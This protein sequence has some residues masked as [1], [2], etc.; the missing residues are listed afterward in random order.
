MHA[1]IQHSDESVEVLSHGEEQ[2][3]TIGEAI[4]N[5]PEVVAE[6][7]LTL[8][9]W[10]RFNGVLPSERKSEAKGTASPAGTLTATVRQAK[11]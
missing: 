2:F 5:V 1:Y 8:P 3:K 7:L 9:H 4:F 6:E 10:H 11:K